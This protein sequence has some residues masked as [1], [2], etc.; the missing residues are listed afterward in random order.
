MV[1]AHKKPFRYLEQD[2]RALLFASAVPPDLPKLATRYTYPYVNGRMPSEPTYISVCHSKGIF[3]IF[4]RMGLHQ[5][6]SLKRNQKYYLSFSSCL[7]YKIHILNI[8]NISK[9]RYTYII[10]K[11]KTRIV[12]DLLF[13]PY[14]YYNYSKTYK[15]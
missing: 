12:K 7:I 11:V 8:K 9:V 14:I 2:E 10:I 15:K 4:Y 1:W 3:H 13:F 5:P 6:H